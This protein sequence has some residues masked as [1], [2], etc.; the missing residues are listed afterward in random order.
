[1]CSMTLKSKRGREP[2]LDFDL[3]FGEHGPGLVWDDQ[4]FT[5]TPPQK[6]LKVSEPDDSGSSASDRSSIP[7]TQSSALGTASWL[8]VVV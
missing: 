8:A 6:S 2:G 7:L 3:D 4:V 1:M 5:G